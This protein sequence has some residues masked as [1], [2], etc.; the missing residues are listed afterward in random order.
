MTGLTAAVACFFVGIILMVRP[1]FALGMIILAMLIYP[2]FMRIS[3]GPAAMSV[4]RLAA[5]VLLIKLFAVGRH[6]HTEFHKVDKIVIV[7]WIWLVVAALIAGGPYTERIGR[8]FDTVV[9]YLVAR[10]SILTIDD[11]KGFIPPLA[12]TAIIMGIQGAIETTTTITPYQMFDR[13]LTTYKGE[14][15]RLGFMRAKSSTQVHIYY[16]MAMVLL[17]GFIWSLR[18]YIRPPFMNYVLLLVAFVGA[19]SSM[20]SGPWL[21]AIFLLFFNAYIAKVSLIKPSLWLLLLLCVVMEVGSNRH[22]YY[23]IQ[24]I[25]LS[26]VTAYYRARLIEVF[27]INWSDWWMIGTG[28]SDLWHWAQQMDG[29]QHLDIV[30]YYVL[31]GTYG[32]LPAVV[33]YI[34]T[35]A[36]AIRRLTSA[37]RRTDEKRRRNLVFGLG[38]T[39]MAIDSASLSASLFGPPLL[40][41]HIL[42]GMAI[43]VAIMDEVPKRRKPNAIKLYA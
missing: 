5:L 13:F 38:A 6:K 8:V 2:E 15:F 14:E 20:S 7:L 9:M 22:F 33:M 40:L 30:N 1:S 18:G 23:L 36:I 11:I 10:Y 12:I 3:I 32:G 35:H 26:E 25:A 17:T 16:G 29:R 43:S 21:A 24:Y 19:L 39:L 42:L 34:V 4:P 37:W 31:M 41:S 28:A 27:L